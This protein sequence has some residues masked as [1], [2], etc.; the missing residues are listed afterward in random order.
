[1]MWQADVIEIR[2]YTRFKGYHYILIVINVMS[3]YAWAM[4]KEWKWCDD[5]KDSSRQW[6][7]FEKFAYWQ[8]EGILQLGC[9]E[10][11]EEV[12][13]QSLFYVFRNEGLEQFN[14][15]RTTCGTNLRTMEN[16]NGSTFCHLVITTR[17][18]IELSVC[19]PLI[20]PAVADRLLTSV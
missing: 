2:L 20:T 9:A 12:R 18:S 5:R 4:F 1:M 11:L 14:C 3:K 15:W 10:T 13:H 7:M 19:V 16:T 8:R 17:T 6:K